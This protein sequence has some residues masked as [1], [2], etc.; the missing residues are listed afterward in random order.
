MPFH[1]DT[2]TYCRAF[3]TGAVTACFDDLGP[4]R[5]GFEQLTYRMRGERS[6]RLRH[7]RG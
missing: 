2:H 7:H 6:N 4:S 1:R 3:S 5:L